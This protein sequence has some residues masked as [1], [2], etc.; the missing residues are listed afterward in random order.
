LAAFIRWT[1]FC[2]VPAH[3]RWAKE[4]ELPL[5]FYFFSESHDADNP[6]P[7][8]TTRQKDTGVMDSWIAGL[9][10]IPIIPKSID[11]AIH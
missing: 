9:L 8:L 4:K 11:P 3:P 5:N 10:E 2:S 7:D 6:Q 1:F